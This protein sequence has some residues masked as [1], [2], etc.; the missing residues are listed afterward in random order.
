MMPGGRYS[1][2]GEKEIIIDCA[3]QRREYRSH[4]QR[5]RPHSRRMTMMMM[6]M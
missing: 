3:H 2:T 5:S 6:M 4:R 1:A